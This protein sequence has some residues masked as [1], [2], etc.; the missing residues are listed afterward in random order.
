M[1]KA[2]RLRIYPH[3]PAKGMMEIF[4]RSHYEDILVPSIKKE[5]SKDH[6]I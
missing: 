1:R 4:N 3:F 5:L 2:R 6:L